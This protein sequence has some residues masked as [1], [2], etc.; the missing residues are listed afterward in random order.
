M[1]P[2]HEASRAGDTELVKQLL[3]DGAPVDEKDEGGRTAL[4]QASEKGHTEVVKLLLDC[5]ASV[6]D[7]PREFNNLLL[8]AQASTFTYDVAGKKA[9]A[10]AASAAKGVND[11]AHG[12]DRFGYRVSSPAPTPA[13]PRRRIL[14]AARRHNAH[15]FLSVCLLVA[16]PAFLRPLARSP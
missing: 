16:P 6:A 9:T 12:V 14:A 10:D 13:P 5:G 11:Q 2:L 15:H 4:M 7:L 3:D 8:E 1:S